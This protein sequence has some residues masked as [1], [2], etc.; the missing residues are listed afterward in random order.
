VNT[1]INGRSSVI[2]GSIELKPI[3]V[4]FS[5]HFAS[6]SLYN[7]LKTPTFLGHCDYEIPNSQN[8][9]AQN[10]NLVINTDNNDSG[11]AICG[12]IELKPTQLQFSGDSA[13]TNMKQ[14]HLTLTIVLDI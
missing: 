7:I 12:P 13:Y 4:N 2:S 10:Q 9:H 3:P 5:G 11:S 14:T 1:F 6:I 8:I